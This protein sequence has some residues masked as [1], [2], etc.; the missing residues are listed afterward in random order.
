MSKEC[1]QTKELMQTVLDGTLWGEKRAGFE[2]HLAQCRNCRTEFRAFQISL[3]LLVSLP[4]PKPGSGFV[5]DTVKKAVLAK[6]MQRRQHRLL[7]WIM[8]LVILSTSML[9]VRGWFETAQSDPNRMLAGLFTGFTEFWA[10][11]SGLLQTVSALAATFWTL[12]KAIPPWSS[13]GWGTFYAEVAIALAI[14]LSLSFI[15]KFRRSKVRTMIF[16]F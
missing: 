5:A 2:Q 6:Q 3:D 7:S 11:I 1:I 8:T 13:S 10:L 15:L 12:I 4:V 16:S 14:T 9:M